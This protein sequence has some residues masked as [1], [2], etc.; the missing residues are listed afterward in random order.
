MSIKKQV[1]TK[2]FKKQV[3]IESAHLQHYNYLTK[4]EADKMALQNIKD[5]YEIVN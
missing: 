3:E 5:L 2:Q 1:S 4:Q